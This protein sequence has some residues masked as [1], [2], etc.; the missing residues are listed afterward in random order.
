MSA[1]LEELL[2]RRPS[3]HSLGSWQFASSRLCSSKP[4]AFPA[5]HTFENSRLPVPNL[6]PDHPHLA[7]NRCE[8]RLAS[9]ATPTAPS[10]RRHY[11]VL[12]TGPSWSD[13]PTQ[14]PAH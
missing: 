14:S 13:G 10:R 8:P 11:T 1:R 12:C 5:N 3:S 7:T 4:G 6:S 2:H 9:T